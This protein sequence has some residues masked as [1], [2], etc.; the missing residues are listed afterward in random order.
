MSYFNP[1]IGKGTIDNYRPYRN[2][3]KDLRTDVE[4]HT[5]LLHGTT[6]FEFSYTAEIAYNTFFGSITFPDHT[7]PIPKATFKASSELIHQASTHANVGIH[8]DADESRERLSRAL[9]N[10]TTINVDRAH[11]GPITVRDGTQI[12][13]E[14]QKLAQQSELRK[15]GLFRYSSLQ[16][17]STPT[18]IVLERSTLQLFPTSRPRPHYVSSRTST[19]GGRGPRC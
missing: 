8:V 13:L 16:T 18:G 2:E 6:E 3:T 9:H 10:I 7:V 14:A 11:E 17:E 15:H 4:Q 1:R 19:F 12:Y 5:K